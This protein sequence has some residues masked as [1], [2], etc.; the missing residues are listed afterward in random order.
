MTLN[1]LYR[2][3]A[4]DG[5]DGD[6]SRDL[7]KQTDWFTT[8]AKFDPKTG[9]ALPQALSTL[10][11]KIAKPETG[12]ILQDRLWRITDHARASVE[13]L[14]R[15]LNESPRREQA[16]LPIRA[17]RELNVNSFIKLSNR[18]GRNIRE[19]LASKPY[20]YAVRRF[21]SVDL[22][23]NRLLKEFVTRLKDLLELRHDCLK[24]KEEDALLPKINSWLLGEEAQSISR[25]ENLP[26]NNT[27]LSHRDYRR[28][29]DAWRWLQKLDDDINSDFSQFETRK[30]TMNRWLEYGKKYSEC[31]FADMPVRFDYEKFKFDPWIRIPES[32]QKIDRRSTAEISEPVCVDFTTLRP[33]YSTILDLPQGEYKINKP[34]TLYE[35]YLWQHWEN[36]D[37]SID[38]E[39]FNSDAVYLHPDATTISSADLFFSKDKQDEHLDRAARAFT[40]KL[41]ETFKN[42][43]FIWLFPDLLNDFELEIIRRNINVGF[44]N[45]QPLPRSIA[46]LFAQIDYS[47]VKN[48]GFQ[49]FVID[50]IGGKTCAT[51]LIARFDPE[52]LERVPETRGYCWER[53]PPVIINQVDPDG[54]Q[55]Y[56]YEIITFDETGWHDKIQPTA[57]PVITPAVLKKNERIKEFAYCINFSES[58]VFGGIRLHALQKKAEGIPLWRDRIP[59]LKMKDGSYQY[60]T[61]VP[62]DTVIDPIRGK[63][64]NIKIDKM[65]LLPAKEPSY[66]F[67]LRLG[68]NDDE[69]GYSATLKSPSFPLGTAVVCR[70]KLE[71]TYGADDPYRLTFE[72]LK[73]EFPPVRVKWEKKGEV[74]DAPAPTYPQPKSWEEL[75]KVPKPGSD[76]TSDLLEW[77]VG[78]I[79]KFRSQKRT[80]GVINSNWDTDR[81]NARFITAECDNN[82]SVRIYEKNFIKEFSYNDIQIGDKISFELQE[83]NGR[84]SGWNVLNVKTEAFYLKNIIRKRLY[85]PFIEIWKDGRSVNTEYPE[86]FADD[87]KKIKDR[88]AY[89]D[90]LINQPDIPQSVKDEILF[91]LSCTHKDT[92]E[93]CKK[94]IKQQVDDGEIINPRVVG[95][96]L[97][98]VSQK[99]QQDILAKLKLALTWEDKEA[100]TALRVFAYAIW[101]ERHFIEKF[102]LK[103]LE[104]ILKTLNIVLSNIKPSP[105]KR[106]DNGDLIIPNWVRAITKPLELLLGLLRTRDSQNPEI[107]M[108]LQPNREITKE[109]EKQVEY[110]SGAIEKT[111]VNI[112]SRVKLKTKEGD[113]TLELLPALRRS[114]TGEEINIELVSD[115]DADND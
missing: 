31:L 71:F 100:I 56:N 5:K 95:F 98:D 24:E 105:P 29:W 32:P 35:T 55:I 51:R 3:Y 97:G 80:V 90:N 25:W 13:C 96:A 7:L 103:E 104:A 58:P 11:A 59:V 48:D 111:G 47:K 45:A 50:T 60:I 41:C 88:I 73:K 110:I 2:S 113:R 86:E 52:L 37:K 17:V 10:L 83:Y 102:T 87:I 109:L 33:R 72:P 57:R 6:N 92:T 74:T 93:N 36:K 9:E 65:I 18:P 16:L 81:N 84:F 114:L 49:V 77:I 28:I 76:E 26:P 15:S 67:P 61:L 62:Q 64:V 108:F 43:T 8:K 94:W 22:L 82:I 106:N 79:D 78:A 23:E 4:E 101:R 27:L 69:V 19:K 40:S 38:I 20:L 75:R 1:E 99:W 39:L 70:L 14:F 85:Y 63:T 12:G 44:H 107:R 21:Q 46:A 30:K 54:T 91:L 115:N 112:F 89:L 66:K 34:D 53:C 42:D 68:E